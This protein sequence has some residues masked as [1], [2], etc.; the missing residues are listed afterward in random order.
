MFKNQDSKRK[1]VP[2]GLIPFLVNDAEWRERERKKEERKFEVSSNLNSNYLK[3]ITN[4]ILS[5]FLSFIVIL[6]DVSTR[7]LIAKYRWYYY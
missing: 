3:E 7:L 1:N 2:I 6:Y 4:T 5:F